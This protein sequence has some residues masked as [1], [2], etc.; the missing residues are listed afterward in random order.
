MHAFKSESY[1]HH[2]CI[3]NWKVQQSYQ[4]LCIHTGQSF[5]SAVGV[6]FALIW[7]LN[8]RQVG[9]GVISLTFRELS[10]IFSWNLCIAD[11]IVLLRIS[12]WNFVRVPKAMLLGT[13]TKF[14]LEIVTIDVISSIVY[15][16]EIILESSWN[17]SETTPSSSIVN[18]SILYNCNMHSFSTETLPLCR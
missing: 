6:N 16:R 4:N 15:F 10:K 18:T 11:I 9:L 14:Q 2:L 3:P 7:T 13:R 8:W 1:M 5:Y 12:S 17:V